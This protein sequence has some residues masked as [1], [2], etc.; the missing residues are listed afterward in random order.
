MQQKITGVVNY[1]W[2]KPTSLS[3][4]LERLQIPEADF[5]YTKK[6]HLLIISPRV[7]QF[8]NELG[9]MRIHLRTMLI[10]I[11]I[12]MACWTA[13]FFFSTFTFIG[14]MIGAAIFTHAFDQYLGCYKAYKVGMEDLKRLYQWSMRKGSSDM[15]QKLANVDL[16]TLILTLGPWVKSSTIA[17]WHADDLKTQGVKSLFWSERTDLPTGFVDKLNDLASGVQEETLEYQ[18]L[19][20]SGPQNV[21]N[22]IKG[23]IL[24][25]YKKFSGNEPNGFITTM[26]LD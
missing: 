23:I 3:P 10:G 13:N 16:Q 14:A 19:G 15:Y 22:Y 2:P 11:A 24:A 21:L 6:D 7:Q 17:T 18:L 20:E 9:V 5:D 8:N 4:S 1:F 26:K 12:A 25:L